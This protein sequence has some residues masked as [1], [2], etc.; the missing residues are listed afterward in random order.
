MRLV[1]AF[2]VVALAAGCGGNGD[3]ETQA[4]PTTTTPKQDAGDFMKEITERSLRGQ[5]GRVWESLHPAHQ[6]IVSRERFDTCERDED[7]TGATRITV[8]VVET[9]EEPVRVLGSTRQEGESEIKDSTAVTLRFN[10]S[11]P[12]T[13]KP[14]EEHQTVHAI[15]VGGEW[16]WILGPQTFNAY[17]SGECPDE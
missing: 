6:A 15:A 5:Y 11:N 12:L 13:G 3:N 14:A 8:K 7:G 2:V 9:Y 4:N 10:Y 1:I 17:V 16:K